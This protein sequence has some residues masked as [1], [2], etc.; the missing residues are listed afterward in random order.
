MSPM[1]FRRSD[2]LYR[3]NLLVTFAFA[4]RVDSEIMDAA[5]IRCQTMG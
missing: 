5:A 3:T 2:D 4:Q 1:I